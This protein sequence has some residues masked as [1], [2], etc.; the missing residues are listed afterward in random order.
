MFSSSSLRHVARLPRSD[1]LRRAVTGQSSCVMP[2]SDRKSGHKCVTFRIIWR[3]SFGVIC[4]I[5]PD[6]SAY[7][8]GVPVAIEVQLSALSLARIAY[9]TSEYAGKGIHVLWLPL[10]S[11]I[12]DSHLYSPRPWERWLDRAYLGRI[13]YWLEG[14][15]VLPL[16]FRDYYRRARRRT[17]D[18]QKLSRMKVPVAGQPVTITEDFR[19]TT[20]ED[21]TSGGYPLAGARLLIDT[22]P[23]WYLEELEVRGGSG[24]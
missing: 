15:K 2:G 3:K 4:R 24:A 16:H 1:W 5:R 12:P 14:V 8:G 7:I 13:Y 21:W 18:Y 9:R 6:V 22:Q 17:C 20:R 10:Y 11:R 19:P 23:R